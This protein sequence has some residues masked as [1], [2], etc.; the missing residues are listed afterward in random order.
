MF[1][2]QTDGQ[3]MLELLSTMRGKIT[4][5]CNIC[6]FQTLAALFERFAKIAKS[7]VQAVRI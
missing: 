2:Y 1:V 6:K 5:L 4:A 3:Q 7:S